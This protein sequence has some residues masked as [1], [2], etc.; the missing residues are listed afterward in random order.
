MKLPDLKEVGEDRV[1]FAQFRIS[2]TL[3]IGTEVG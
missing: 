3:R 1:Y 2:L